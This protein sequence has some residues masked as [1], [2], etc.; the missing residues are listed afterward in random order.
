MGAHRQSAR[1]RPK[2][3]SSRRHPGHP[4]GAIAA[5]AVARIR[6]RPG[7]TALGAATALALAA[8]AIAP[9]TATPARPTGTAR[10]APVPASPRPTPTPSPS[11]TAPPAERGVA[12]HHTVGLD[13][14]DWQGTAIDWTRVAKSARFAYVKATEGT[15]F[16]SR[17]FASQYAGA[18]AA[19]L[20]VGAYA[21]GRPDE[22]PVA[23]AD[24]FVEEARFTR[25]GKTLPPM[26][27]IEWPYEINGRIVADYPCYG[28][29]QHAMVAWIVAFVDEVKRRTG[30][31]V[32]IYTASGWWNEC[33]G[34]SAALS[35]Q[36]L[37]TAAYSRR[38][39]Q[40]P[41][42]WTHWTIWQYASTGP[43]PGDQDVLEGD[44]ATLTALAPKTP[45]PALPPL[46]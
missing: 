37:F 2:H 7:L 22:P 46:S 16:L 19:G 4:T 31:P 38:A 30:S 35:D 34:G 26:L 14:S 13:V 6:R 18:K 45:P 15:T 9:A 28:M 29:S 24:H 39:P 41:K 11:S 23:Q 42:G 10:H 44:A 8:T 3:R 40:L 21:F 25:D 43:L 27:D 12:S 1:H 36:P 5:T 20:Y 17:T 33:T 32:M